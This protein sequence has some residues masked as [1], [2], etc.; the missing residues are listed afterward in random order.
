M[1][2]GLEPSAWMQIRSLPK[3]EQ[4]EI[5]KQLKDTEKPFE[6]LVE[7]VKEEVKTKKQLEELKKKSDGG[8]SEVLKF[9]PFRA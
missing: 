6:K 4:E 8:F 9:K 5:K 3:E 1:V 7:K 2:A